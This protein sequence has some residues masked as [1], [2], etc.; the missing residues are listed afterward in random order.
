MA[1]RMDGSILGDGHGLVPVDGVC[2]MFFLT[3]QPS[4]GRRVGVFSWAADLALR[5]VRFQPSK[6]LVTKAP[7]KV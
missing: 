6:P 7:V 4:V 5:C 3:N 1:A 2:S